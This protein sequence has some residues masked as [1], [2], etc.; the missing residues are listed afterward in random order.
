MRSLCLILILIPVLMT[1]SAC[2]RRRQT[3]GQPVSN[4]SAADP[5]VASHFAKGFYSI[6][7]NAWRWTAKN[8]SVDLAPPLNA[9]QK[10]AQLVLKLAVPDAAL[11]KVDSVTLT[12]SVDG[13]KLDPQTYTKGGQY[14]FTRDIPADKLQSDD[15]QINFAVD[16]TIPPTG[17]DARELG[18]IVSQVGLVAK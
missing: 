7:G 8:F 18:L 6:E 12:A 15:V 1:G 3:T 10:G 2:K 5:N 14:T 11:Q 9:N 16:H 17:G 4:I 13:Y